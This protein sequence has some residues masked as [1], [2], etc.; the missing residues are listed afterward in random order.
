MAILMVLG[1]ER[2]IPCRILPTTIISKLV[3]F[4][5]MKLARTKRAKPM[6]TTGFLPILSERGPKTKGPNP[7]PRKIIVMSNWLST[8]SVVPMVIPII[9]KAGNKASMDNATTDIRDAISA[10][11]SNCEV[12]NFFCIGQK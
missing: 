2:P 4:T 5:Q 12:R 8:I 11:N 6:Y 3:E 1:A 10:T 9:S 7:R